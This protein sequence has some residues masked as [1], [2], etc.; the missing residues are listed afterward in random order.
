MDRLG[1]LLSMISFLLDHFGSVP[2][3]T[4][5]ILGPKWEPIARALR[6]HPSVGG[7]SVLQCTFQLS[8]ILTSMQ[9]RPLRRGTVADIHIAQRN[10]RVDPEHGEQHAKRFQ[11]ILDRYP[12]VGL[13]GGRGPGTAELRKRDWFRVGSFAEDGLKKVLTCKKIVD[14]AL[15][16]TERDKA[17]RK[18]TAMSMRK[19][20]K[21]DK[22]CQIRS[23]KGEGGKCANVG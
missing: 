17:A 10:T 7:G 8:K 22:R 20:K 6:N 12:D 5:S 4:F 2:C 14:E 16:L 23:R 9:L 1:S 13:T 19:A 18:K 11:Q 3:V 21:E 15:K